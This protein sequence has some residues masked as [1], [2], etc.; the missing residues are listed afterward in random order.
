MTILVINV[1][2]IIINYNLNYLITKQLIKFI[3][4]YTRNNKLKNFCILL[5]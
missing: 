5:L 1:K 2:A 3:I 4:D